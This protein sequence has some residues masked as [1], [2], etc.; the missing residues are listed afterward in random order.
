MF[1]L[2]CASHNDHYLRFILH[3]NLLKLNYSLMPEHYAGK[4]NGKKI[5]HNV[6]I[7]YYVEH[8]VP[9]LFKTL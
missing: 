5:L 7:N 2:A 8:L 1:N 3:E 9:K 4:I 6:W